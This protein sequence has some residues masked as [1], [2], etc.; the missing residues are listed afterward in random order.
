VSG[1]TSPTY[2]L[3]ADQAPANNGKQY[4]V[5]ALGGTQTGVDSHAISKPFTHAMFRP[6]RP[7]A[8]P[9]AQNANGVLKNIPLNQY[10]IVTR[11]GALV[12]AANPAQQ[13]T[14]TTVISVPA[15]VDTYEPEE[16][17]AAWSSHVGLLSGNSSALYDTFVTGAL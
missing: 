2:T 15:G 16:L 5:S 3:S 8:L 6:I 17:K 13:I 4:F 10:K 14:I 1:L 9:S 11:K 7:S 12:N